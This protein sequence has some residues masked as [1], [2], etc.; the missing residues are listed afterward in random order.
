MSL[1]LLYRDGHGPCPPHCRDFA[2]AYSHLDQAASR[3]D[4]DALLFLGI[5]LKAGEYVGPDCPLALKAFKQCAERGP[6]ADLLRQAFQAWDTGDKAGAFIRYRLAAEMGYRTALANVGFFYEEGVEGVLEKDAKRA[7]AFYSLA[8]D[9]GDVVCRRRLGDLLYY[10]LDGTP[11]D[12]PGA[13]AHYRRAPN[14][15][16]SV[17]NVA[18]MLERG[19]GAPRDLASAREMYDSA[20]E[21][22][23][24]SGH[25]K[26]RM[27]MDADD[28]PAL[29]ALP[30]SLAIGRLDLM[31]VMCPILVDLSALARDLLLAL[32]PLLP[33][34]PHAALARWSEGL[35]G[36]SGLRGLVE[37][38][39]EQV[40]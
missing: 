22:G 31:E 37:S 40:W 33:A 35:A 15:A 9:Q 28:D 16:Q 8:A 26:R 32:A 24:G 19:E 27:P 10:G 4:S 14:D 12:Y 36:W 18:G 21:L 39:E 7:V 1:G 11:P 6:W 29:A 23:G 5:M 25:Q 2:K 30:A 13:L 17:F 3:G 38:C 20:R 34:S